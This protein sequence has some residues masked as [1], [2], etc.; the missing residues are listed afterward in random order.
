MWSHRIALESLVL[1]L[2]IHR[3]EYVNHLQPASRILSPSFPSIFH[4]FS[5]HFRSPRALKKRLIICMPA[6]GIRTIHVEVQV[7]AILRPSLKTIQERPSQRDRTAFQKH[8][9]HRR[10]FLSTSRAAA[11][12][13][14]GLSCGTDL[15][16]VLWLL[17][18]YR[19]T[20]STQSNKP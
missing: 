4:S 2:S 16:H 3:K 9:L 19:I 15:S 10:E 8:S 12:S 17:G 18:G 6:N 1:P 20:T 5:S 13:H 14:A 11:A 7:A